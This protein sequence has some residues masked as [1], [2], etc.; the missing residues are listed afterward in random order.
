MFL[1]NKLKQFFA[2][3]VSVIVFTSLFTFLP[4]T[5]GSKAAAFN[6]AKKYHQNSLRVKVTDS[7]AIDKKELKDALNGAG[8][9]N[10]IGKLFTKS[11]NSKVQND[12]ETALNGYFTVK[13]DQDVD[14]EQL[15]A[16]L[17]SVPGVETAYPEAKPAP[18]PTVNYTSLQN[19]LKPAGQNGINANYAKNFPGG[20]GNKVKII[21]IEY[22]WNTSHEDLD[23]AGAALIPRG[24]PL[25]PFNNTNHGTAVL[26][27]MIA[28]KD[29]MGVTGAA[30]GASLGLVNAYSPE[31]G[32]DIVGAL[33]T[34]SNNTQP[35]DVILI[36]QQ[37]WGPSPDDYDFVPVEWLP[38][39]YDAIKVLTDN[40]RTVIEPAGNGNQNL[41]D[42]NYFGT[43][44]P[45]GKADSGA[46]IV[47]AGEN[48]TSNG[49]L[50]SR[51]SFSTYG[52]RVNL[53]GPG[54][55]VVTAGYGDL[56]SADANAFYTSYFSGTSSASPVV[57]A[58]AA[59]MSSAYKQLNGNAVLSPLQ[60][61]NF[62]EQTG[63]KQNLTSGTLTGN[64]GELPNLAKALLKTDTTAPTT[65]LN[66]THSLNSLN[67]PVLNWQK[68]TDN[69]KVS[70]YKIYRNGKAYKSSGKLTFT[71]TNVV[72]GT[73]YTYKIAAI[74]PSG[75]LSGFSNT[76]TVT[77]P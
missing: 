61:R 16:K 74:D 50:R 26:G 18:N 59:S 69:N 44:F 32:W 45:M 71:D 62:L 10:K 46:I 68:S 43:S 38:E 25:D 57:A 39:I 31:Y 24:T 75:N 60:I 49:F 34:A 47:G 4:L 58:A 54:S 8:K 36:E 19:Y 37:M 2:I 15:V 17:K 65:P 66:L 3:F 7:T 30:Y 1:I 72:A 27:E 33:S 9:V 5:G 20:T 40:G 70:S 12:L 56:S 23:K 63:T 21:D 48:C 73:T 22:S 6:H 67:Q 14:M 64:I 42:V 77:I 55:C 35:G 52:S 29:S 41:D 53:Q 76:I 13:Y 11:A 51:L 28:T